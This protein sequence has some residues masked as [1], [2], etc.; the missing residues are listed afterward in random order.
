VESAGFRGN[1]TEENGSAG[2]TATFPK[3]A[4]RNIR[5]GFVEDQEYERLCAAASRIGLWLRALFEVGYAFGWRVSELLNL[6][7]N[8]VDLLN[9]T[10]S[11]H[12]GETKNDDGRVVIMTDNVHQ[13]LTSC[14]LGKNPEDFVFTRNNRKRVRDFRGAW[15]SICK[16]AG[17][18]ERLFHDLRRTTVRNIVRA[19]I[20]ERVAMQISG[21][22]T[23]ATTSSV[24]VIC[25]RPPWQWMNIAE[26]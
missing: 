6:R 2:K 4:E 11:L 24:R 23:T 19:G 26:K 16:G 3:L 18:P 21:H 7:V 9:R 5:K 8:Q 12:P 1:T 15:E 10:I 22:K 17:V 25:A 14:A 13:F 20:P